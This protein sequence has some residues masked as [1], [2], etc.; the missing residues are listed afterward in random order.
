MRVKAHCLFAVA[1]A[2]AATTLWSQAYINPLRI[3][4]NE[5]ISKPWMDS[6]IHACQVRA[7]RDSHGLS[8]LYSVGLAGRLQPF[9]HYAGYMLPAALAAWT[10]IP[11]YLAFVSL[12]A[13]MGLFL[14]GLAA[15]ALGR[16]W[17]GDR[18]GVGAVVVLL[19]VPGAQYH[20]LGNRYLGF[21]WAALTHPGLAMAVSLAAIAWIFLMEGCRCGSFPLIAVGYFAAALT[22]L[23]KAHVFVAISLLAWLYPPVFMRRVGRGWRAAWFV[24]ALTAFVACVEVAQHL[25]RAPTLQLDGSSL[26][27]FMKLAF[28]NNLENALVRERLSVLFAPESSTLAAAAVGAALLFFGT[29][30]WFGVDYFVIA[31]LSKKM[32]LEARLF[33]LLI[34]GN[35]LVMSLGLAFDRKGVGSVDELE[36]PPVCLGVSGTGDLGRRHPRPDSPWWSGVPLPD[37]VRSSIDC[38]GESLV[39]PI[40][41]RS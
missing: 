41:M 30:G 21:H 11:T 10:S 37:A 38:G 31:L 17:W 34:M 33:P 35:Y 3:Q 18:G 29:F 7:F 28:S 25:E 40:L 36:S 15:F 20:G 12:E 5:I 32:R 22:I 8:T 13:P 1:L 4:G 16:Y 27:D 19:L 2:L 26:K 39:G 6:Y 23:F 24:L 9:Y 14:S